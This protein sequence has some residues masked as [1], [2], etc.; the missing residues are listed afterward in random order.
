MMVSRREFIKLTGVSI[1]AACVG[2]IGSSGCR[3]KG[4]SDTP[5][6]PV[7]SYSFKDGRVYLNLSEIGALKQVGGG[8]KISLPGVGGTE[9]KLIVIHPGDEEYLAFAD[10][11]SHKGKELNYLHGEGKLACSG[12]RSLYDLAGNVIRRPAENP[13]LGYVLKKEKDV[14][15][16]DI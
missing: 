2:G 13:L 6:A 12:L 15:I 4:V 14:L 7:G 11:C 9:L 8:V 3:A 16:I 10:R 1:A 5:S